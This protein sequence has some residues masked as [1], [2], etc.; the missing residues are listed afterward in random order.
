MHESSADGRDR[1]AARSGAS[2]C[3]SGGVRCTVRLVW[4]AGTA[5]SSYPLRV[6][7]CARRH[8]AGRH[9]PVQVR[10]HQA[11]AR[12]GPQV[13]PRPQEPRYQERRGQGQ[14]QREGRRHG[15]C[16][17]NYCLQRVWHSRGCASAGDADA[18]RPLPISSGPRRTLQPLMRGCVVGPE[19]SGPRH[20][21][22]CE[23]TVVAPGVF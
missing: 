18:V 1:A 21:G 13:H 23:Q 9:P 15:R 22:S 12:Q 5:A 14:V 4:P 3:Q 2:L 6:A 8:R 20:V 11:E 7:L 16:G 10:D 17:L 19:R